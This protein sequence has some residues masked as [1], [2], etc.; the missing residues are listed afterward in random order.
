MKVSIINSPIRAVPQT[1]LRYAR[2]IRR[3]KREPMY[4]IAICDDEVSTCSELESMLAEY[5]ASTSIQIET[6]IW[7]TGEGLCRFMKDGYRCDFL[8]LD[9][10]LVKLS[11][12]DV[13]YFIRNELHDQ[14]TFIIYVSSKQNY[15]MSL[16]KVQP[17]DFLI[18]PV[19]TAELAEVLGRG[20]RI[21]DRGK[22]F[23]EFKMGGSYYKLPFEDILYFSSMLKKVIIITANR[24]YEFYGKLRD[25]LPGLAD[26]FLQ[27]HQ[28]YLVNQNHV[29]EFTY[30]SV[31]MSNGDILS[32]SKVNR[33]QVRKRIQS[34]RKETESGNA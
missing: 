18:K 20:I 28:S 34:Y 11:G 10:E 19:R 6:E 30:D 33:T 3:E 24:V 16:F 26:C 21:L 32:V 2:R 23:F 17:L 25:I 14:K 8:L 15:A 12:L 4:K 1:G 13:G 27:I 22:T 5:A 7:Y 29:I 9:I 31:K